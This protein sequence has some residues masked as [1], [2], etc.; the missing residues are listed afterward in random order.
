[1]TQE[2]ESIPNKVTAVLREVATHQGGA[3]KE[4]GA[5]LEKYGAG[6]IGAADLFKAAGDLYFREVG[7]LGANLFAAGT[8]LF[9]SVLGQAT[10]PVREQ[11]GEKPAK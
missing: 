1:M 2:P 4:Y 8:N 3:Y 5:A 11:A 6:E 10:E 7:S 9:S